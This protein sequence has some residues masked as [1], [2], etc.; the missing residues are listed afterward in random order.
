[1]TRAILK[2]IV[3]SLVILATC[4]AINWV[5]I[6]NDPD[7]YQAAKLDKLYNLRTTSSPKIILVG[8]SNLAFGV[9]SRLLENDFGMP[10]VNMGLAKS[11]GLEYLLEETKPYIQ[12]DDI[13]VLAF[14]YEMFFDMYYGSDG[15]IVELQYVPEGF[16]HL[17]SFGQWETFVSKFGPIMQ[18]KFAGYLRKGSSARTDEVYRRSGFNHYGDLTTHLDLPPAYEKNEIFS[19]DD[20]FREESIE[21]LNEFYLEVLRRGA[22]AVVSAPPLVNIEFEAHRERIEGLYQRL[23]DDLTI[24]II[25]EPANYTFHAMEMYDTAYHLLRESRRIRTHRLLN[26]LHI[27]EGI[28]SGGVRGEQI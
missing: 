24:P 4:A 19:E 23:R 16:G 12:S 15:L 3:F 20:E 18:A 6:P 14:E 2:T 17:N 13:V 9:D 1:M 7:A 11:V 22:R 21:A 8:G 10:V 5:L 26:D 28:G 27:T 25:S